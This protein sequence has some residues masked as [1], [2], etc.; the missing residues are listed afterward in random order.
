MSRLKRP[1]EGL[2]ELFTVAFDFSFPKLRNLLAAGS[3][4]RAWPELSGHS[5]HPNL[6]TSLH[7]FH[8]DDGVCHDAV[9]LPA[10]NHGSIAGISGSEKVASLGCVQTAP[11]HYRC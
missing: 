3:Y 11:N 1:K 2:Q 9:E 6:Q 5:V 8:R 4:R 10:C 7:A